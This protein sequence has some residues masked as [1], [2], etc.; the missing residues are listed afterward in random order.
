MRTRTNR[1]MLRD[2]TASAPELAAPFEDLTTDF[3][4]AW[5]G[6]AEPGPVGF[7]RARG[8]Y[9]QVVCGA[10]APAPPEP[11]PELGPERPATYDAGGER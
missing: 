5:Y 4:R 7:D 9:E 10:V 1:E 11:E 8:A 2:V 3:E 6:H